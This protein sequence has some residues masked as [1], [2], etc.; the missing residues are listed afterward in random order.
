MVHRRSVYRSWVSR[1]STCSVRGQ[2]ESS[3]RTSLSMQETPCTSSASGSR[4][5][6][7]TAAPTAWATP[8]PSTEGRPGRAASPSQPLLRRNGGQRRRLSARQRPLDRV[9]TRRHGSPDR[10]RLRRWRHLEGDGAGPALR[11]ARGAR[12]QRRSLPRRLPG[13]RARRHFARA[14]FVLTESRTE[15]VA[16]ALG[17]IA[18]VAHRAPVTADDGLLAPR[19]AA[20]L[21]RP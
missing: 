18:G 2:K 7:R 6:G 12:D 15:V 13:P 17:A 20:R 4:T 10:P 11:P 5:G 3:S 1:T 19:P 8:S 14:F 16:R 9:R 21:I